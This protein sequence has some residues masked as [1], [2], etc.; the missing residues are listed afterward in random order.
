[1][2][3]YLNVLENV[4]TNGRNRG[5]RTG[6][7]TKYIFSEKFRHRMSDGFPLL[8]TKKMNPRA[9]LGELFGFLTGADSVEA[10]QKF[11]CNIWNPWGLE[12]DLVKYNQ[13]ED[14]AVLA[15]ALSAKLEISHEEAE[16]L[17]NER[18]SA[19]GDWRITL[20][21]AYEALA[22]GTGTIEQVT[23]VTTQ[24]PP[25]LLALLN[26]HG[27]SMFEPEY[28][29]RK[30][31][32]GPIY[33]KQW[34]EWKCTNGDI[35]NQIKRVADQLNNC[36]TSRRIVLTAWN[37]E[38]VPEDRYTEFP[39]SQTGR[40]AVTSSDQ[41]QCAILDGK[42][43]LPPC[44]LMVILDVDI[45]RDE[46]E[47]YLNMEVIM[48]STDVPIGLPYNITSYA[49]LLSMIAAQYG[50][51]PGDLVIEMVNCH[52]YGDQ[53]ELAQEQITRLPGTLPTLKEV[54]YDIKFDDPSTLTPE[55]MDRIL[56]GIEGYEPQSF[57]KYPVAV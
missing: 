32:L 51:T 14:T 34:L 17:I 11:G 13:I 8:T 39:M 22:N 52:V 30:G 56:A 18:I 19:V 28:V 1:M 4:I 41:I 54:P 55:N 31:Y 10:F 43:A 3:S 9:V 15:E 48:R 45:N 25:N 33:G 47:A 24:Q 35:I 37:P 57:I 16:S 21:A 38:V 26:E 20:D 44:H 42:Q 23:E 2:K 29:Y 5:N 12:N 50:Y 6:I 53:I 46:G 36:P 49:F 27:V 7:P 40:P